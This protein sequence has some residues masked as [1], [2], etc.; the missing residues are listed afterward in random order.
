MNAYRKSTA[1]QFARSSVGLPHMAFA[2]TWASEFHNHTLWIGEDG[3]LDAMVWQVNHALP[4]S[5]PFEAPASMHAAQIAKI[6]A[7][8]ATGAL[9]RV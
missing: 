2:A 8:I 9:A 4:N 6:T 3:S 7:A 5:V 1:P